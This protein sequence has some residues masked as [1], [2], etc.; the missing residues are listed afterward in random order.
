MGQREEA[1]GWGRGR[2]LVGGGSWVGQ[3]EE[4]SGWRLMGGAEGGG[5]WVGRGRRLVGGAEGGGIGQATWGSSLWTKEYM[6]MY[7][8]LTSSDII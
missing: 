1:H 4:A 7:I 3:R 6:Y 2:R 5:W 8:Y